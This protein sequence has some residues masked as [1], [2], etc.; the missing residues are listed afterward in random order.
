MAATIQD[1]RTASGRPGTPGESRRFSFALALGIVVAVAAGTNAASP[2]SAAEVAGSLPAAIERVSVSPGPGGAG[3]LGDS[4]FPKISAD[5][6]WVVF[7]S[8][9][10]D[11]VVGD[12]NGRSDVFLRDLHSG[13]TVMVSRGFDGEADDRSWYPGI[14]ADGRWVVFESWA[15]NLV[16]WDRNGESD[17]FVWDRLTAAL[18]RVSVSSLGE[19]AA[20]PSQRPAISADGRSISFVSGAPNLVAGDSNASQDIF[21]HDR[22]IGATERVSVSSAG[23]QADGDSWDSSLSAD[24]RYVAFES[25]A[26]NLVAGDTNGAFDVFVF[27]RVSRS[28]RR[29]SVSTAGAEG[30]DGSE[31]PVL[32]PDGGFVVFWSTADNLTARDITGYSDVFRHDLT[33]GVTTLLSSPG[34]RFTTN[35]GSDEPALSGDGRY[36]AFRSFSTEFG[37]GGSNGVSDIFVLDLRTGTFELASARPDGTSADSDSWWP[38]LSGTGRHVAFQSGAT[39][40]M[41][42]DSN[43]FA[44]AFVALMPPPREPAFTDSTV[45]PASI[46]IESLAAAGIVAG[47]EAGGGSWEFRP[48]NPVKRAQFAK[49]IVGSLGYPVV[50]AVPFAPF[51]DLGA[52]DLGSLYPH[53]YVG[54]AYQREITKG[55]TATEFGPYVNIR[56]AQLITMV[57]RALER[58]QPW[59]LRTP[60]P[61]WRGVLASGDA[62]HGRNI[63]VAEYSG[64]L[65]GIALTGWDVWGDATRAE[66]AQILFNS[67]KAG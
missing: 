5:G 15:S 19:E 9:A 26:G 16:P 54:I 39:T 59:W 66:T 30:N 17:I 44:D 64:L 1:P 6:R 47:Y 67:R 42:G 31:D 33:T 11:L 10:P 28:T 65:E 51:S 48:A 25:R 24:G 34:H 4:R 2:A 36:V 53:E 27:D 37:A 58:E 50:E 21:V 14:S 60:P 23:V 45:F 20:G 63:A 52:D 22:V 3:G 57:V 40:L 49:M 43:G 29:A 61:G 62:T 32:S 56:R 38:S 18:Q 13:V 55:L 35:A 41:P 7:A 46:A 8:E 12:T